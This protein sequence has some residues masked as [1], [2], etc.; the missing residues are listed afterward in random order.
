MLFQYTPE[1]VGAPGV[2]KLGYMQV[3]SHIYTHNLFH[4]RLEIV[5][6]LVKECMATLHSGA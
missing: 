5:L 1:L 2:D 3:L 6:W 4:L